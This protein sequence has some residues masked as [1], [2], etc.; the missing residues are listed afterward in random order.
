MTNSKKTK[1]GFMHR[2][3]KRTLCLLLAT[4][5]IVGLL[6]LQDVFAE[7][8]WDGVGGGG[9]GNGVYVGTYNIESTSAY[10]SIFG[11]RFTVYDAS[12]QRPEGS[13]S[14]DIDVRTS[15]S[16]VYRTAGKDMKSHIDL[17][18]E[19]QAYRAFFDDYGYYN[20]TLAPTI[21]E[22]NGKFY[23]TSEC[24]EATGRYLDTSMNYLRQSSGAGPSQIGEWLKEN[25]STNAQIVAQRC[26]VL[27]Y[28]PFTHYII[29]EPMYRV[30]LKNTYYTMTMAELAVYQAET[31]E[32]ART[33]NGYSNVDG[34]NYIVPFSYSTNTFVNNI[35]HYTSA[36]FGRWL[37]AEGDYEGTLGTKKVE[38]SFLTTSSKTGPTIKLPNAYV[39][40]ST[41]TIRNTAANV[42][43]YQVGMGIFTHI[44]AEDDFIVTVDPGGDEVGGKWIPGTWAPPDSSWQRHIDAEGKVL[45]VWIIRSLAGI[46]AIPPVV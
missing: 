36:T 35:G 32:A 6:P 4:I 43:L 44:P 26:G 33:A 28:D 31:V 16:T 10:Y 19:Y 39:N 46:S 25:N 29:V 30:N 20:Q 18:R 24:S 34:W 9:N 37:Y 12:G 5:T 42:L 22:F 27:D 21:T 8:I 13:R 3:W 1:T 14:I 41:G 15:G 11:F 45:R 2:F 7:D 40:S 17:N 38:A 23:K